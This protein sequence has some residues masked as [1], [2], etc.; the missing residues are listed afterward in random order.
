M[1]PNKWLEHNKYILDNID[2]HDKIYFQIL[3]KEVAN[4]I[5]NSPIPIVTWWM[6][7]EKGILFIVGNSIRWLVPVDTEISY[8]DYITMVE[9]TARKYY[10][11]YYVNKTIETSLSEDEIVMLLQKD[12]SVTFEQALT[13]KKEI[14]VVESGM[15][16]KIYM[17]NDEFIFNLNG[18]RYKRMSGIPIKKPMPLSEFLEG[19]RKINALNPE[20]KDNKLRD[21]ILE[22]SSEKRKLEEKIITIDYSGMQMVNFFKINFALLRDKP[23]E[24]IDDLYYSW[25]N[26]RIKF[27]SLNIENACL[28]LYKTRIKI[29]SNVSD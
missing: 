20:D 14:T 12:R 11:Q 22:N 4:Y 10:P 28:A 7:E 26:F 8:R 16:E 6:P 25:G 3:A 1:K 23:F 21:F 17:R 5:K 13:M 15:I 2:F 24:R 27:D 18:E 9:K 19:I 29:N